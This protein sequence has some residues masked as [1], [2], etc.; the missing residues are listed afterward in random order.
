MNRQLLEGEFLTKGQREKGSRL[1][2]V[3][4][5]LRKF[6]GVPSVPEA[7]VRQFDLVNSCVH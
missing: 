7:V 6:D 4:D 1:Q 5:V 2:P 3:T